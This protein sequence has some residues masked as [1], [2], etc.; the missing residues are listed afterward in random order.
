MFEPIHGSAPKHAGKDKVN[1]AAMILAVKE[2][3]AWLG[4]RKGDEGLLKAAAAI[5]EAVQE[6]LERGEPL[7]YDLVGNEKA[8]SCSAMGSAIAELAASKL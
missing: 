2:G 8:A 3:L 1:P 5:E 6:V 4:D 7:T